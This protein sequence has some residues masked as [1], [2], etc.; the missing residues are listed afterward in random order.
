MRLEG[1]ISGV[2]YARIE[3]LEQE[4]SLVSVLGEER[5][6]VPYVSPGFIDIQI[7]GFFGVD[8]S[9]PDLEIDQLSSLLPLLWK[10]GVTSFCPLNHKSRSRLRHS[11]H[12]WEVARKGNKHLRYAAQYMH[13]EGPYFP[14]GQAAGVHN[15]QYLRSPSWEEFS[16][17]QAEAG[18]T[19]RIITLAPELP[20][21]VDS[22]RVQTKQA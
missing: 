9:A 6:R 4:I 14:H 15:P 12:L 7:D 5:D 8:F 18:G 21:A 13:L 3:I 22:L 16:E 11:L 1:N 19:I 2:G 17:L 10:T 20:G